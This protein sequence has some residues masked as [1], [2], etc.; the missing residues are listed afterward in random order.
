MPPLAPK[1]GASNLPADGN[2]I[3]ATLGAAIEKEHEERMAN[4]QELLT[5]LLPDAS[6][7]DME[8]RRVLLEE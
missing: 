4:M 5:P 7:A 1:K 3:N 6:L 2:D 8:K